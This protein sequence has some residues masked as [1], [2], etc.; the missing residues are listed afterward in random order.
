MNADAPVDTVPT[1]GP[2]PTQ[3]LGG[4]LDRLAANRFALWCLLMV[5]NALAAP[6][7]GLH[8]DARLY[9]AQVSER[10]W[11]G[12]YGDDLYLRYGSQDRYSVFTPL[13]A[14]LVA[15]LGVTHSFLIVYLLCKG[16]FLWAA[17]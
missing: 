14:P 6:Y 17:L 3:R 1:T 9:A 13:I 16:L 5:L 11:P 4:L 10:I 12:S 2:T 8:H 7:Q 15:A